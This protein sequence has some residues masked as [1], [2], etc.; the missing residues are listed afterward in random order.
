MIIRSFILITV[1][2]TFVSG[3][4]TFM[5]EKERN[6]AVCLQAY[7]CDSPP[8]L[9]RQ[10]NNEFKGEVKITEFKVLNEDFLDSDPKF[11]FKRRYDA[12]SNG[13]VCSRHAVLGLTGDNTS[14]VYQQEL[15]RLMAIIGICRQARDYKCESAQKAL[16]V[17]LS[18]YKILANTKYW[19]ITKT[20]SGRFY[21]TLPVVPNDCDTESANSNVELDKYMQDDLMKV[22]A[23]TFG[24]QVK[25]DKDAAQFWRD[26]K[27]IIDSQEDSHSRGSTGRGARQ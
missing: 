1:I 14:K 12:Y 21:L 18:N 15:I 26:V 11:N 24:P 4:S 3:C 16:S 23:E 20:K 19:D 10:L 5:K 9:L 22:L 2:V 25:K 8:R 6:V 27:V 13:K 17:K 7:S